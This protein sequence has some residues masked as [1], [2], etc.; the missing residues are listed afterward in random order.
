MTL[1]QG[2]MDPLAACQMV[3]ESHISGVYMSAQQ[4]HEPQ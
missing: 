3:A 4:R 1:P 2:M